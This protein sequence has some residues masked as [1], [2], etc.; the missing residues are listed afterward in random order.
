MFLKDV[1]KD[2]DFKKAELDKITWKSNPPLS[3][4]VRLQTL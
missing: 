4:C 2:V 1:T 3:P